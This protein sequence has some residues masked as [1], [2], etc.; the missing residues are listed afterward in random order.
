MPIKKTTSSSD[1]KTTTKKATTKKKATAAT[2]KKKNISKPQII[3]EVKKWGR[4]LVIVESPA[5]A[6]TIKNFLGNSYEVRASMGHVVDLPSKKL[7]IDIK[8]NFEPTYE[9]SDSKKKVISELKA[10]AKTVDQVWIATDE[11]REGE[12]IGW[13]IANQLKLDTAK[14][15]RIV[16]HEITKPA[17]QHAIE[18]Y[19][20]ID[21]N[22]VDAQQGRRLLDRLVW[23]TISPVL[24]DKIK[25]WLSAGRVQSVAVKLIVEK[26]RE[27]QAFKPE[28]HW[29]LKAFLSNAKDEL[30][31][32]LA[33]INGK[34]CDLVNR[35]QVEKFLKTLEINL[36]DSKEKKQSWEKKGWSSATKG[37]TLEIVSKLPFTL[38]SIEKK[39]GK[40]TPPAPFITSTLQQTAS[41]KLWRWVKQVMS[42]AQKL[43]ENGFITYMR[44]DSTNL[45]TV[46]VD[47]CSDFIT[48]QYGSRYLQKR[49]Y[50]GK[51][52]NAQEAHEAIRPTYI[53]KTPKKSWLSAQELRLYDL[54][55]RRTVATQMAD[56][57]VET[58]TYSFSPLDKKSTWISKGQVITF[59]GFLVLYENSQED[60]ILPALKEWSVL[61]SKSIEAHQQYTKPPARFTEAS[62][63]KALEAKGI[64]RPSTYAPTIQTIQDRG[65]VV[66][67]EKKLLPTDIA[68]VV[69]D[70][71]EKYFHD[72]MSYEFTAHLENKLD[73]IATGEIKRQGMMG[74]FYKNFSAEIKK[75]DA[76][77]KEQILVWRKCPECKE[78]DLVYKFWKTGKFI[79]CSRYPDC[80]HIEETPEQSDRLSK[81]KELYEGKPC[82]AGG[83]IVVRVGR[84]GPFLSSSDYPAVKRIQS[85]PDPQ[86]VEL[87][88]KFGGKKCS[89]CGEGTMHVKKSKR[90]PFLACD[91]YPDCKNAE[92][93]K[94]EKSQESE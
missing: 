26:E 40:K 77:D 34:N 65:Y 58:T 27:I 41:S 7:G 51:S 76:G 33:K 91:H 47:A 73:E 32:E 85:I 61:N 11:D 17:I 23:F 13:H 3:H 64:G 81:L 21:M 94:I 84:F 93:I 59:D 60:I 28:E 78:G 86:I 12:A 43:Y 90:G 55:W 68:F 63:V 53:D 67:E 89:K 30:E 5:K 9:V 16:F 15:P 18:N 71:L 38:D 74:D 87:E 29:K 52:A 72:L 10:L 42:V 44:T 39:A 66:K 1:K 80:K 57:L 6:K 25:R 83:T 14:T 35:D 45:S 19:R 4:N 69:T 82:P 20:H 24:W 75:A 56:A 70:Y 92:N 88:N 2:T 36:S 22:L 54:I 50:K 37:V 79:G 46:A 48:A 31:C 8:N 49:V 62:L